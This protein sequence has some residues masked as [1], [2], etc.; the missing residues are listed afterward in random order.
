[1]SPYLIFAVDNG[2]PE[3]DTAALLKGEGI[4]LAHAIF[5]CNN[6]GINLEEIKTDL[7]IDELTIE[8]FQ[9]GLGYGRKTIFGYDTKTVY[10]W[11]MNV[12]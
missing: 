6:H 2:S 3:Q 10:I 5:L 7:E 11:E 8:D 9:I 4:A 12:L 1:M